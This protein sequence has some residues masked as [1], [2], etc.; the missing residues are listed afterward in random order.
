MTSPTILHPA[1]FSKGFIEIFREILMEHLQQPWRYDTPLVLDPFAGVGSIHQ[2]RP[3]F[4][5]FGI[6]IEKEWADCSDFT[7]LGDSTRMPDYW[8]GMFQAVVTSPTYGN[9]MAD[10][11]ER[12]YCTECDGVGTFRIEVT[13]MGDSE[14]KWLVENCS[15]C[16]GTGKESSKRNTYRHVLGRP[17][18]PKNTGMYQYTQSTYKKL[19]GQVYVECHRVLESGGLMIVNLSDHIRQGQIMPVVAW[20]AAELR[21]LGFSYIKTEDVQ[22]PRLGFGENRKVR[23]DSEQILIFRR[24]P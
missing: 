19:H 15:K 17:L 2:L 20:H 10:H 1:K 16:G 11:H 22:T 23:V 21:R 5:T 13:K 3:Q 12:G 6:E 4:A 7:F 18:N 24:K 9:R 8:N 14:E